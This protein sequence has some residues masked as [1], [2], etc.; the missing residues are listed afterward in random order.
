[1]AE[2]MTSSV[3][4]ECNVGHPWPCLLEEPAVVDKPSVW[5]QHLGGRGP[6]A[7]YLSLAF[8]LVSE[9]RGGQGGGVGD[10]PEERCSFL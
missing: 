4:L 6:F 1:M 5:D 8:L 9:C 7:E 2:K 10:A 3:G